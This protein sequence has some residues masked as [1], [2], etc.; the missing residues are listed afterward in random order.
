MAAEG[1]EN[2][3]AI[4]A[5]DAASTYKEGGQSYPGFHQSD[6][7]AHSR[8]NYAGYIDLA[9]SPIENLQVDVAGRFEHYTDFG[10]A[11]VGKITARYDITP[12]IRGSRHHLHRL[13]RPDHPGRILFG[14]QHLADHGDGAVAAQFRRRG[15]AGRQAA[16]AGSL[17]QLQRRRCRPSAGRSEPH[18]G[19]LF[20]RL[21]NRIVGTGTLFGSG[22]AINSPIVT[23]AIIAHGNV[24]DP[25]VTQTGVSI[26]LNGISTLTQG[27]DVSANYADRSGQT[28]GTINWTLAGNYT[29]TS[30]S[31]VIPTPADLGARRHPVQ[32]DRA[33]LADPCQSQGEDRPERAVVAG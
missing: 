12:G 17:D 6:A 4:G 18:G 25:T 2:T 1:R 16:A 13:P 9:V 20:D 22:G 11:K 32:P 7:G 30:I 27:V 31:K 21:R 29:D 15:A 8:K 5:G 23:Q 3:F 28:M 14:H 33:D 26:F 10:D 24:L 19:R